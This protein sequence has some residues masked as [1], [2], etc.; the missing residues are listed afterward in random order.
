MP[1]Q[2][3]WNLPEDKRR[4]VIDAAVAEFGGRPFRAASLDRVAAASG[5]SKGSLFQYFEDKAELYRWLLAEYLP[6]RKLAAMAAVAS[7]GGGTD[8]FAQLE[9]SFYAGLELFVAEPRL[10]Q[11]A[12]VFLSPVADPE[13]RDLH[14]GASE[15][16]HAALVAMVRRAQST[17]EVRAELA[18]ET[19][20]VVIATIMGH[21]LLDA[22]ARRLGRSVVELARDTKALERL[23]RRDLDALVR[24]LS[25]MLRRAVGTGEGR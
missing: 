4:R 18:P 19:V 10:A 1:R 13:I 6:E 12:S 25:D 7:P 2:T 9:A 23:P 20:A 11:L 8:L 21:G 5:V 17:G 24:E 15:R 14:E 16:S 3:F 22:L